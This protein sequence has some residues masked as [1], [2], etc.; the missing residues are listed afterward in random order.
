VAEVDKEVL[1][2]DDDFAKCHNEIQDSNLISQEMA[3]DEDT[4]DKCTVIETW[5][6][7]TS[8]GAEDGLHV[9]SCENCTLLYEPWTAMSP[10]F[11]FFHWSTPLFGFRGQGLVEELQPLQ[12]E[13]N[14]I[15]Q[16]IQKLMTLATSIVWTERG[17]NVGPMTNKDWAMRQYTGRPPIFQTTAS[18]SGEYFTQLDRLKQAA[19]E[20]SGISQMAA[21][22]LKPAGLDS[23]AA[24]RA[25]QDIGS[26]RFRHTSQRWAQFAL[27]VGERIVECARRISERGDGKDVSVLC[28]GDRD[29]K[30]ISFKEAD[31]DRDKYVTLVH[32]INALPDEPAGKIQT[33]K[34]LAQVNPQLGPYLLTLLDDVPDLG[35]LSKRMNAQYEL[36]EKMINSILEHGIYEGP[37]PEM[38]L[39]V[40]RQI[41]TQA[42]LQAQID[43]APEHNVELLRRF[44]DEVDNLLALAAPPPPQPMMPGMPGAPQDPAMLGTQSPEQGPIPPPIPPLK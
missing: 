35:R 8:K 21:Q 40:T 25:Y 23:G 7:P 20:M 12:I 11:A 9:I 14:Y 15:A 43:D 28:A 42:L 37:F 34:E 2:A 13:I 39:D 26:Q 41:A 3:G 22:S 24:L 36:P 19:Y 10:P 31:L 29:I 18:V 17:S 1:M 33:L 32:P 16:K 6:L 5:L 27:D 30:K 44:M 38:D 4:V